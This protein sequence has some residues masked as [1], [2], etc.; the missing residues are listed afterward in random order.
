MVSVGRSLTQSMARV[1]L[2]SLSVSDFQPEEVL[3]SG[4]L[5]PLQLGLSSSVDQGGVRRREG[6]R[7]SFSRVTVESIETESKRRLRLSSV[8]STLREGGAGDSLKDILFSS[9]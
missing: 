1:R 7:G 8:P 6:L 5:A 9:D 3:V 2:E 4:T